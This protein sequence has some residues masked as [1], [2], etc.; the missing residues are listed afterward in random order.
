[1]P[2]QLQLSLL[3]VPPALDA[4]AALPRPQHVI[5]NH[6]YL[7][8][9]AAST[10]AMVVGTTHRCL[11]GGWVGGWQR[12]GGRAA[13]RRGV[14]SRVA[15]E[16]HLPPTPHPPH[17][18]THTL[19]LPPHAGTEASTSPQCC[20]SPGGA[21]TPAPPPRGRRCRAAGAPRSSSSTRRS[22]PH[23]MSACTT[24][25]SSSSRARGTPRTPHPCSDPG[26]TSSSSSS[27]G[28]H[29]HHQ[30]QQQRQR[31]RAACSG[32]GT[33][34][35]PHPCTPAHACASSAPPSHSAH[36]PPLSMVLT[37]P[38]TRLTLVS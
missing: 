27:S 16:P 34:R 37:R 5:L 38:H 29:H 2:P 31:R 9:A 19:P 10:T 7:Q 4:I 3:N 35:T 12:A 33:P 28:V 20:T 26:A 23:R 11:G 21:P 14:R 15:G 36:P 13:E 6:T 1:M 24:T 17:T 25:S 30:Q 22:R 18:L 32:R 8:R